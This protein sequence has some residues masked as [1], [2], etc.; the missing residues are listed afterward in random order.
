MTREANRIAME[1]GATIARGK[2][3]LSSSSEGWIVDETNERALSVRIT[4]KCLDTHLTHWKRLNCGHVFAQCA[5]GMSA[6]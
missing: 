3:Q 5:M 1:M 6:Q 4:D 2:A